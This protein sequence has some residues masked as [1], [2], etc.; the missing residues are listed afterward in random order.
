MNQ[1]ETPAPTPPKHFANSGYPAPP[2]DP[3]QWIEDQ[4]VEDIPTLQAALRSAARKFRAAK[5]ETP[6]ESFSA[7]KGR[8][9]DEGEYRFRAN[10][11]F[12]DKSHAVLELEEI[13]TL[14]GTSLTSQISPHG[15]WSLCRA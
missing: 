9:L 14:L 6:K 2:R 11:T 3:F 10:I 15:T 13:A 4:R 8:T 12:W 5:T 1:N 7:L